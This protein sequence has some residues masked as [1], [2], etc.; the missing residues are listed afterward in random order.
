MSKARAAPISG[1][2]GRPTGVR[3][4]LKP[5]LAM[6]PFDLVVQNPSTGDELWRESVTP[7]QLQAQFPEALQGKLPTVSVDPGLA[8]C[9]QGVWMDKVIDGAEVGLLINGE[10]RHT[11][12]FDRSALTFLIPDMLKEGDLVQAVQRMPIKGDDYLA[13]S[14]PG[15]AVR[16]APAP[17]PGML[18]V[19]LICAGARSLVVWHL[20]ENAYLHVDVVDEAGTAHPLVYPPLSQLGENRSRMVMLPFPL[21]AGT[22]CTV[23]QKRCGNAGPRAVIE[24]QQHPENPTL[25]QIDGSLHGCETLVYVTSDTLPVRLRSAKFGSLS[26]WVLDRTVAVPPLLE[27]DELRVE[28]IACNGDPISSGGSPVLAALG[29]RQQWEIA[30]SLYMSSRA[31]TVAELISGQTT[32]VYLHKGPR[33]HHVLL[34]G[35]ANSPRCW[36]AP[37]RNGFAVFP[38]SLPLQPGMLLVFWY[39]CGREIVTKGNPTGEVHTLKL[40]LTPVI[41]QPQQQ[42]N[43]PL[44]TYPIVAR[45]PGELTAARALNMHLKAGRRGA[46]APQVDATGAVI[47]GA[48]TVSDYS[49]AHV[50]DVWSSNELGASPHAQ[51]VLVSM[52][53]PKPP[54][55]VKAQVAAEFSGQLGQYQAALCTV[56]LTGEGFESGSFASAKA[57]FRYVSAITG[58]GN[59]VYA[60]G[61]AMLNASM[62]VDA[63]GRFTGTGQV[64]VPVY[65]YGYLINE[66]LTLLVQIGADSYYD[67][68]TFNTSRSLARQS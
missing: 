37:D 49:Q 50:I 64:T 62:A 27:G 2:D 26:D 67:G 32:P 4:R 21:L 11:A 31:D 40:P 24:V 19:Q 30:Q 34:T 48:L 58:D 61:D 35:V 36:A 8:A 20:D 52:A 56:N 14:E 18:Q 39:P 57:Q 5:A 47:Q 7:L 53:P 9:A 55:S 59:L 42:S 46:N 63:N 41:E 17:M 68:V 3:L 22:N 28:T 54:K 23:W 38:L 13:V 1:I 60:T 66:G 6:N 65:D 43:V 25:P 44:G 12:F 10:E 51:L 45:D 15:Q 29:E 16:V 33:G